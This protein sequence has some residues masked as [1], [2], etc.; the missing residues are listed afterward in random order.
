MRNLEILKEFKRIS[1]LNYCILDTET[2]GLLESDVAIEIAVTD[3]ND[4]VVFHSFL[5]ENVPK[6]ITNLT[7]INNDT[8]KHAPKYPQISDKLKEIL[9]QYDIVLC[10]NTEFDFRILNQ[11][12][13]KYD[14][15][16][17]YFKSFKYDCIKILYAEYRAEEGNYHGRKWHKLNDVRV[18]EKLS[19]VEQK[20]RAFDDCILTNELIKKMCSYI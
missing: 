11:T 13:R 20:H 6:L 19:T 17:D 5:K 18:Y 4:K 12:A 14:D 3:K 8:V 2:T 10:Y 16:F 15:N 9:S 1:E 7:G